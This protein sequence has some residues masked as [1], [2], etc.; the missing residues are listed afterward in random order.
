M[1]PIH[2]LPKVTGATAPHARTVNLPVPVHKVA[3]IPHLPIPPV[4]VQKTH[5]PAPKTKP[6]Y[7]MEIPI[8]SGVY[9]AP[10]AYIG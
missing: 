7:G 4:K 3:P 9:A 1:D 8:R 6:C 10:V 2:L 5:T